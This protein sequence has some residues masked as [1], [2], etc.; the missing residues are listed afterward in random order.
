MI[1]IV[2]ITIIV[3]VIRIV[4]LIRTRTIA[5]N[6]FVARQCL[7]ILDLPSTPLGGSWGL[8]E[9]TRAGLQLWRFKG[10]GLGFRV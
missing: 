8:L 10:L 3:I 1:I 6:Q 2:I 7:S 4:L 9:L 5:N